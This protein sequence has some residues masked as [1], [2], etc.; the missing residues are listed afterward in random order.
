MNQFLLIVLVIISLLIPLII[1]T[2]VINFLKLL[3]AKQTIREDG[4]KRH[5]SKSLTPTIGGLIFLIPL[6]LIIVCLCFLKKEFRTLDLFIVFGSTF[7]MATLGF[8]DD[9][10]KIQK[11]QNKG[12]SGWSKLFVQ[13]L[14][15]LVIYCFYR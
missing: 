4:P 14:I 9:C 10:L 3:G 7:A 13:F 2:L 6:F 8:I 12:I 11:N 15:S 5:I 1:G